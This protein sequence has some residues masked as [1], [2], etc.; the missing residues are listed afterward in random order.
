M[1]DN[2]QRRRDEEQRM[3]DE[4]RLPPGQ[5]LTLKFPVLHYG[6]VPNFDPATWTLSVFGE[7]ERE[8]SWTWDE[9]RQIPTVE[10]STDIHCVT[11]GASSTRVGRP[12][13]LRDFIELFGLTPDARYVI[14]HAAHGFTTNVPLEEHARRRR[15]PG[16]EST[17]ARCW[18]PNTAFPCAHSSPNAISGRAPSGCSSWNSAPPT[19]PVSG[20]RRAI[21]T[22]A[23][24]GKCALPAAAHVL[25]HPRAGLLPPRSSTSR[26]TQPRSSPARAGHGVHGA[27]PARVFPAP[28]I[29]LSCRNHQRDKRISSRTMNG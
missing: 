28:L 10:V 5:S 6:P 2:F 9:F 13:R 18:S 24:P 17:T 14:A 16:L 29:P 15:D 22:T 26:V 7:V 25:A 21:T 4:G 27:A 19:S 8:M 3:Q 20:N 12:A 11:A 1:T 23:I